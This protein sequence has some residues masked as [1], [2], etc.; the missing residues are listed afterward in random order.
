MGGTLGL[1]IGCIKRET[2]EKRAGS[3][4]STT[5]LASACIDE[6]IDKQLDG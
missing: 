1:L 3:A 6:I 2:R 5:C 4:L